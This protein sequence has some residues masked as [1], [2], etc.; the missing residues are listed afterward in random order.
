MKNN[1]K[2]DAEMQIY[3]Q[4]II[5]QRSSAAPKKTTRTFQIPPSSTSFIESL[6]V[7]VCYTIWSCVIT[8]A[9]VLLV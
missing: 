6:S 1:N 8:R 9:F 7:C 5:M 3:M 4:R 2:N